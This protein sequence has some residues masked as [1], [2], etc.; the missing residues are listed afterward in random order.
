MNYREASNRDRQIE[1]RAF[2]SMYDYVEDERKLYFANTNYNALVIVDKATWTVEQFIPFEGEE[3]AAKNLH[4][5]CVKK[6]DKICFLPAESQC[7]RI[8]DIE[9]GEQSVCDIL[10]GSMAEGAKGYW[11]YFTDGDQIYLLPG[12]VGQK[13]HMWNAQANSFEIEKWWDIPLQNATLG[14]D[15]MD[16]ERFFS[17]VKESNRLY[18]TDLSQKTIEEFFLPDEHIKYVTYDGQNFW[19]VTT[20]NS[21]IVC[22]SREQGEVDRYPIK[23][24]IQWE[25]DLVPCVGICHAEGNLFLLFYN[26]KVAYALCVLDIAGRG[27]KSIYS[28]ECKRGEFGDKELEPNFKRAGNKLF[29]L[30]KNA[31]EVVHIDLKTLETRQYVENFKFGDQM[32]KYIYDILIDKGALLYEEPGVVDLNM[33]IKHYIG[34]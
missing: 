31:G 32:Q 19:Y 27:V 3:R 29:C 23:G 22:W 7:V 18:I 16:G 30:L 26:M 5:R 24:D 8:Y 9:K 21:D 20:D 33:L 1:Y 12:S 2:L 15:G 10:D 14:H 25:K 28:V 6:A 13:M 4:L 34:D 11:N 17:L